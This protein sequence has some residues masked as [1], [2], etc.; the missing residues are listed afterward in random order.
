MHGQGSRLTRNNRLYA[1]RVAGAT[2]SGILGQF[3]VHMPAGYLGSTVSMHAF[4]QAYTAGLLAVCALLVAAWLT[5]KQWARRPT[6]VLYAVNLGVFIPAMTS[7]PVVAGTVALWNIFLLTSQVIREGEALPAAAGDASRYVDEVRPW[8]EHNGPAIRHLLLLSIVVSITV[9]G[10]RLTSGTFAQAVSLAFNVATVAIGAPFVIC[11][12]RGR[13]RKALFVYLPFLFLPLLPTMSGALALLA[14]SHAGV[15]LLLFSQGPVFRDLVSHFFLRPVALALLTF[16]GTILL[17]TLMLSFPAASA[18]GNAISPLE[19]LFTATSATCVTGLIV[20]DTPTAFSPFGHGVILGLI[21]IGGLGIMVLSTFAALLLGG[22][23]G[24]RGE[25][26][27]IQTLEMKSPHDAYRLTRFIVLATIVI[28]LLGCTF[29]FFAFLRM[30]FP[31]AEAMWQGV[32]HAVSAFCNAGFSLQSDSLIGFQDDPLTLAVFAVLIAAGG[33]G[34]LVM[35]SVWTMV[36]GRGGRSLSVQVRCVLWMTAFL[37][38][39]GF[40]LIAV[41]EWNASLGGL[42]TFDKLANALFQSVTL[43]TA[44]FN[45]VD[46]DQLR[47]GT[48][49]MM[50]LFMFVGASPGG[51]GGGIKTTTLLVLLAGIR[52][53]AQGREQVVLFKRRVPHRIVYRSAAI[54]LISA[55]VAFAALWVLLLTQDIPLGPLSFEVFSAIG[56]VGLSQGATPV[57]DPFGK[58]I[59]IGLMF[60]GRLGPLSIALLL[61]RKRD[62]RIGY[63]ETRIMVG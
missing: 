35:A 18:T 44:G 8:L 38:A 54:A 9:A 29:L 46:L 16:A 61:G 50:Q 47:P 14:V 36:R 45:S 51:T 19:A 63:P 12:V 42:S 56:T 40:V 15:L 33:V 25:Q 13:Q 26:A 4:G 58:L 37:L 7:D 17:G 22:K 49:M 31:P 57:L 62:A 6:I 3:A 27:L 53:I 59:V 10:F 48:G 55:G 24:L 20:V 1:A 43:R 28:E 5:G 30:G 2:V 21:Q 23:L 41:T 52:A 11:L 39:A 32:F 34:F 60:A